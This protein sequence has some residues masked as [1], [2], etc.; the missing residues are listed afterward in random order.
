MRTRFK[1]AIIGAIKD[2][3][4]ERNKDVSMRKA[5]LYVNEIPARYASAA[6][7]ELTLKLRE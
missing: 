7:L 4:M 1:S 6:Y 3:T 5:V 2:K